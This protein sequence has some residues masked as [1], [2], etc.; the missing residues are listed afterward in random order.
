MLLVFSGASYAYYN[1][2][3]YLPPYLSFVSRLA[4]PD[5]WVATDMPWATAWYGDRASLW[6]PETLADFTKIND[7]ICESDFILFTPVTLSKPM[8]NL[9]SGEQKEWLPIVLGFHIPEDFPLHHVAKL[10]A[11]GPE[12][13][14]VSNTLGGGGGSTP[15]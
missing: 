12:Y 5:Q 11:G 4:P 1:Y 2:P 6:L 3:P 10:P 7:D 8:T 14:I 15:H 9:T 13:T